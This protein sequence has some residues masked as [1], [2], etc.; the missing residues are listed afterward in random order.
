MKS[1]VVAYGKDRTIGNEGGLPWQGALPAD[2]HHFRELTLARTVI[3]GRKTF[4]SIG[5]PLPKRQNIVVSR[6]SQLALENVTFARSLEEAYF[7]AEHDIC[8]IGGGEIFRAALPDIDVVHATEIDAVF[9]GDTRFLELEPA[10]WDEIGREA[11]IADDR[12]QF[13]YSFVTYSK[14]ISR[15]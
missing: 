2:M 14:K 11:H 8:V 4:E 9:G 5:R 6:M 7:L 10:E 12:N 13:D 1:I 3:M 15:D